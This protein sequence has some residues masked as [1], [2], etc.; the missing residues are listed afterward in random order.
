MNLIERINNFPDVARRIKELGITA[1]MIL[2]NEILFEQILIEQEENDQDRNFITWF[3]LSNNNK[4][5]KIFVRPKHKKFLDYQK[6]ILTNKIFPISSDAILTNINNVEGR[7]SF[8]AHVI[9]FIKNIKEKDQKGLYLYGKMG[10]GKTFLAQSVIDH[11]SK[12]SISVSFA[13]VNELM[14]KLKTLMQTPK[15]NSLVEVLKKS[16]VLVLDDIGAETIS[17]WFRDEV[18][19]SILSFRMENKL[20]TIFTSN[21]SMNELSKKE[22]FTSNKKFVDYEKSNRLME[23]IKALSVEVE[24]TGKNLRY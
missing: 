8:F 12:K 17:E 3:T 14:M 7:Q 6:Y 23:R 16:S 5:K 21:Y 9:D 15:F 19:F 4:I 18:L 20:K 22:A 1:E 2:E 10:I 11:V 24:I 13:P